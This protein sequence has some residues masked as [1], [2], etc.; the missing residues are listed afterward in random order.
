MGR[1]R[2]GPGSI[3]LHAQAAAKVA[4]AVV[5]L[6]LGDVSRVK[7][8]GAIG[9]YRP[10]YRIYLAKDGDKLIILLGGGTKQ[11]QQADIERATTMW[12]EYKARKAA[13]TKPG[14]KR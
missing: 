1:T 7:W 11:R 2:T 13:A 14:G 9:E 5:R 3:T 8:I 6:E 4:T 10:G 12:V